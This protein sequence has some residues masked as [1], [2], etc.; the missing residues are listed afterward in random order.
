[1]EKS[2]G[3]SPIVALVGGMGRVI[4]S[5]SPI[6]NELA[7]IASINR[8]IAFT[9]KLIK[10][11]FVPDVIGTVGNSASQAFWKSIMNIFAG[12]IGAQGG[13]ALKEDL[14]TNQAFGILYMWHNLR[15]A[16]QKEDRR[17]SALFA[18]VF[19]SGSRSTPFTE[20]DCAQKPGD[21]R[22]IQSRRALCL[23]SRAG[24]DAFHRRAAAP[25]AFRL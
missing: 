13:I 24:N 6:D 18:F 25:L 14:P 8:N 17:L 3:S 9:T 20:T 4:T 23:S 5:S 11:G 22:A 21:P 7:K 12:S 10:E 1:M 2:I 15:D 16:I 19:G